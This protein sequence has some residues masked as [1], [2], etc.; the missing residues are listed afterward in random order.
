M[1]EQ[2]DVDDKSARELYKAYTVYRDVILNNQ[3]VLI[4]DFERARDEH[5]VDY[6]SS[7]AAISYWTPIALLLYMLEQSRSPAAFLRLV[8]NMTEM[9]KNEAEHMLSVNDEKPTDNTPRQYTSE[10]YSKVFEHIVN[11]EERYGNST[12]KH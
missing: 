9:M 6:P 3:K 4:R 5:Q 12:T 2:D 11:M 10:Q 8:Q 1:S 7:L